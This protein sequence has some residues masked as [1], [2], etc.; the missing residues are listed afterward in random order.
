M[1]QKHIKFHK[2]AAGIWFLNIFLIVVVYLYCPHEWIMIL[3][4][5]FGVSNIL[6][7]MTTHLG[8]ASKLKH[9]TATTSIWL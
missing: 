3:D 7:I 8:H 4:L 2:A 9:E 5:F 6:A 1:H